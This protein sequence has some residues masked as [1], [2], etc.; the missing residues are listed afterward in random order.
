MKTQ[1]PQNV[2]TQNKPA[3]A[4]EI[5]AKS[6]Q[7]TEGI[8]VAVVD[9]NAIIQ[10]GHNLA[11]FADKFFTVSEVLAEIR[12]PVS[13][14]RLNFIPFSI[15][16]MEPSPESLHKGKCPLIYLFIFYGTCFLENQ[17]ECSGL[18]VI[19]VSYNIVF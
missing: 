14:H 11:N 6:C 15:D 13:R 2:A 1:P 7:S 3:P 5:L 10:G 18:F 12:D 8:A 19:L 17:T 16:S 9:A 4:A